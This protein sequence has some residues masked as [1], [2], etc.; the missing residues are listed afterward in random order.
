MRHIHTKYVEDTGY[1]RIK[2]TVLESTIDLGIDT[3][4]SINA[5]S[6]ST[7]RLMGIRPQLKKCDSPYFSCHGTSPI[8]ALG[9]FEVTIST[10]GRDHKTLF[11]IFNKVIDDLLSFKTTKAL[12][13][14]EL[15]YA[16][17]QCIRPRKAFSKTL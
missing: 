2:A 12:R 8:S 9:T 3:Q 13:L 16:I 11:I 1:P 17:K 10:N 4:A 14:I 6:A 7:Y 5:M 15:T